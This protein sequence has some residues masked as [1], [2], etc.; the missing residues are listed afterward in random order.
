MKSI[1]EIKENFSLQNC[2]LHAG[3]GAVTG[4]FAQRVVEQ[5]SAAAGAML[6]TL[7]GAV[8]SL[9]RA[10][11]GK[12]AT[13][14]ETL[15]AM[16]VS[17]AATTLTLGV[18]S[19]KFPTKLA[20]WIPSTPES[21]IVFAGIN[22]FGQAA[23][24]Y[25]PTLF[26]TQEKPPALP[27]TLKELHAAPKET[28]EKAHTF[29]SSHPEAFSKLPP[30]IQL[31]LSRVFEKETMP[32]VGA[33]SITAPDVA[34]WDDDEVRFIHEHGWTFKDHAVTGA[35]QGRFLTLEFD[36]P[37]SISR[38][39]PLPSKPSDLTEKQREWYD[40]FFQ[41]HPEAWEELSPAT[42]W[43]M[44]QHPEFK[45]ALSPPKTTGE[46]QELPPEVVHFFHDHFSSSAFSDDI[47]FA[48][49]QRFAALGLSIEPAM[50]AKLKLL[51]PIASPRTVNELQP[52][53]IALYAALY[54][55][56]PTSW[57]ALDF[58]T[59]WAFIQHEGHQ[60]RPLK[61]PTTIEQVRRLSPD[62]LK[63][64][65]KHFDAS[66]T[67]PTSRKELLQRFYEHNDKLSPA[68]R[69]AIIQPGQFT[70]SP[71]VEEI[72]A[73]TPNQIQWHA[74]VFEGQRSTWTALS[75]AQQFAFLQ[76]KNGCTFPT[77][78][79]P[80]SVDQVNDL[81][82]E[83]IDV[84]HQHFDPN[85]VRADRRRWTWG[86]N[87]LNDQKPG[88]FTLSQAV[89]TAI[90]RAFA[91]RFYARGLSVPR[92]IEALIDRMPA[93]AS[94]EAIQDLTQENLQHYSAYYR[95]HPEKWK[96]LSL[97][98]QWEFK[99]GHEGQ[100]PKLHI[101]NEEELRDASDEIIQHLYNQSCFTP[102]HWV[103]FTTPTQNA[104][105]T[106]F[107]RL[108]L[109]HELL[110]H[111]A[112]AAN[113]TDF[114]PIM[115]E[116]YFKHFDPSLFIE[117]HRNAIL[118]AFRNRF[119]TQR[120]W[121]LAKTYDLNDLAR[122]GPAQIRWVYEVLRNDLSLW[123]QLS[124]TMQNS[125][126]T[127]FHNEAFPPMTHPYNAPTLREVR[128]LTQDTASRL[129]TKYAEE[130]NR[131]R[132][133]QLPYKTQ[134]ALRVRFTRE[135]FA[136][137]PSHSQMTPQVIDRL[138]AAIARAYH[139]TL[140]ADPILW[141]HFNHATQDAFN[142]KFVRLHL[143]LIAVPTRTERF[144]QGVRHWTIG[145]FKNTRELDYIQIQ[146]FTREQLQQH[147]TYYTRHLN[148][149]RALP[150]KVQW[151]FI[152]RNH[153]KFPSLHVSSD[154]ELRGASPD[155]IAH[156]HSKN[157][158]KAGNWVQ[159]EVATQTAMREKFGRLHLG[160]DLAR[161]PT[162]VAE[163]TALDHDLF[164][165]YVQHFNPNFF[166]GPHRDAMLTRFRERFPA[167]DL[168]ATLKLG[169]IAGLTDPEVRWAYEV[170]NHRQDL[171]DGLSC[172]HQQALQ[173]R[174]TTAGYALPPASHILKAL[175]TVPAVQELC[176]LGAQRLHTQYH[177]E[178]NRAGWIA[179]PVEIQ[180]AF[181]ARFR[182]ERLA[183]I[184][185]CHA[186][187]TP[188]TVA[189]LPDN[190]IVNAI[191]TAYHAEMHKDDGSNRLW[192]SFSKDTRI[193]F[194][195]KF[196]TIGGLAAIPEPSRLQRIGDCA[197]YYIWQNLTAKKIGAT[198][199]VLAGAYLENEGW[200][201]VIPDTFFPSIVD[202][203]STTV[204]LPFTWAGK[205]ASLPLSV[206]EYFSTPSELT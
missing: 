125:L 21:L 65:H 111:P 90:L 48:F 57:D 181:N 102:L 58:E 166:E 2:A 131:E 133:I 20:L 104:L 198:A 180:N 76:R 114:S 158:F 160:H 103:R 32:S 185:P 130:A 83:M 89:R 5:I 88:L 175:T 120:N 95:Q 144:I 29:Y 1:N 203:L 194:N 177:G 156:L 17:L 167:G 68:I 60:W 197:H 136:S 192:R 108:G 170:L 123:S 98:L 31:G 129:H 189:A 64:F 150:L 134:E 50:Q 176:R 137:L 66:Q 148:R 122:L 110:K 171:W 105:D 46:V 39:L 128:S 44:R 67:N 41:Q 51:P 169:N 109:S 53:Q 69:S 151:E 187:M 55:F 81:S 205:I 140:N 183:V 93:P 73:L 117:S 42:Q 18:L 141:N 91:E 78:S 45:R 191:V 6:G 149:W 59:Q 13:P 200:I 152:K 8:A 85:I 84:F 96:E 118:A 11:T 54:Q 87:P 97:T 127:R 63:H 35:V 124:F 100:F 30:L 164:Q 23:T 101:P 75:I 193:A 116:A 159:L 199:V 92:G 113:V 10:Y 12:D 182:R 121:N 115:L 161:H 7:Y 179:L 184:T 80:L 24:F 135:G 145:W 28:V 49:V 27:T 165:S 168:N 132:W 70:V 155:I 4:F 186:Q 201:N 33:P 204:S 142:Q 147:A 26:P 126:T 86:A 139:A 146:G 72:A 195:A 36:V 143:P 34:T 40:T 106:K 196:A 19:Q 173:A 15:T 37:A 188:R 52:A 138:P 206:G 190:A 14:L 172:A 153:V 3:T 61:Y 62:L 99:K 162:N 178:A 79:Y 47:G 74:V 9:A 154:A 107:Q 202:T 94:E 174:F 71:S 119:A 56:K 163:V 25:L 157:Y 112:T 16:V 38:Q 82:D 43:N 22:I 77:L